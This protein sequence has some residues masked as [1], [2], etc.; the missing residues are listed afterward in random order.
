MNNARSRFRLVLLTNGAAM[1]I[2]GFYGTGYLSTA[3][4]FL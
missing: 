1:A 4:I 2:G 3:E